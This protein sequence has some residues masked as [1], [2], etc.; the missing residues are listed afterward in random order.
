MQLVTLFWVSNLAK[1]IRENPDL[2]DE[3]DKEFSFTDK[4]TEEEKKLLSEE[5]DKP[6]DRKM[7]LHH[8][9]EEEKPTYLNNNNKERRTQPN[10]FE[11]ISR[12]CTANVIVIF[13]LD[14]VLWLAQSVFEFLLPLIAE[15]EYGWSPFQTGLV[16]M[17]GGVELIMVFGYLY[18]ISKRN[19]FRDTYLILWSLVMTLLSLMLLIFE[20]LMPNTS[21]KIGMFVTICG[22]MFVAVPLNLTGVKSLL[23]KITRPEFQGITQGLYGS[24]CSFSLII[25]PMLGSLIYKH[26][27][28]YGGVTA[29]LTITCILA[30]CV[31]MEKIH[32]REDQITIET[33]NQEFL[34]DLATFRS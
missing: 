9:K 7:S 10:I 3:R 32:D 5:N 4:A 24:V 27:A 20:R 1:S 30:L 23:S 25:G 26:R 29:M 15:F 6:R 17:A 34:K 16:Y 18:Y 28:E 21:Q 14:T 11:E 2:M 8:G 19:N 31:C 33:E 13:Y 22:L 12:L